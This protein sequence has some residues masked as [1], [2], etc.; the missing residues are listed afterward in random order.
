MQKFDEA[1]LIS[2]LGAL[3]AS[4][5]VAFAAACAER[6]FAAYRQFQKCRGHS[7]PNALE[8]A[9]QEVW[10]HPDRPEDPGGFEEEIDALMSLV[11]REDNIEGSWTQD[12]TNAQNAGMAAIYA[13]RARLH[14]APQEAA[15]A[16]RVAYEALD[17]FVINSEDI[18]TS[19][20]GGEAR[21]LTH[22]LVQAELVRQRIDLDDLNEH[23]SEPVPITI[24]RV[25]A[26]AVT[27]S[28]R[29]FQI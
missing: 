1:K 21:V 7:S 8:L 25:R 27:D 6:Q 12:A 28:S 29:F 13:L 19:I 5:R 14:A 24:A 20:P 11:P 23:V 10:N 4:F 26:R 2:D 3:P 17:N 22:P 18:D 16:A 9:L 15:W